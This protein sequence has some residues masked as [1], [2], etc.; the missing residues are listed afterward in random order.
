MGTLPFTLRGGR[1]SS[2]F[3]NLQYAFLLPVYLFTDQRHCNRIV[4]VLMLFSHRLASMRLMETHNYSRTLTDG[5]FSP[6]L[7]SCITWEEVTIFLSPR[8]LLLFEAAE[9]IVGTKLAL[10]VPCQLFALDIH[11]ITW[12]LE[13]IASSADW[14][15]PS[16]C[17][18]PPLSQLPQQIISAPFSAEFHLLT[19]INIIS[20]AEMNS[21]LE[22]F[23]V[24]LTTAWAENQSTEELNWLLFTIMVFTPL[25][26]VIP[27]C[28]L[29]GCKLYRAKAITYYS[30]LILH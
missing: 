29:S 28:P 11:L 4:N 13:F 21:G 25:K 5:T 8:T 30:M 15:T 14:A 3:A 26:Y 19:T 1:S 12:C 17:C 6:V 9:Q 27:S 16:P 7:Y 22:A 23:K 10:W 2:K 18:D 20:L 24:I